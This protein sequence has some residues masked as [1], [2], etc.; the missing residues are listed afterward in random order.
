M[1][2]LTKYSII[3][4]VFNSENIL[5][6]TIEQTVEFLESNQFNYEI[7]LVN[8][9][10]S[11]NSWQVCKSLVLKYP[12]VKAFDLLKNYGQH[13]A[14]LCGINNASGDYIITMDD[15]LQNPPEELIH[16]I[17][18]IN[19]GYDAVFA[20]FKVKQH[21]FTRR[22][23]SKIVNRLN[24]KIFQ[25]PP[26]IV[27][28]NFRIISKKV[29]DR[30]R[31]YKTF[32]PYIPGLILMFSS[33]IAN[34][35]TEHAPRH[36]GVSNYGLGKILKLMARL[37]FNYSS[38][39]L[40]VLTMIG[41]S[42]SMLSFAAGTYYVIKFLFIGVKVPGWTTMVV[43]LSFLNGFMIIMMGVMGEYLGRIM[44]QLSVAQAYQIKEK[45]D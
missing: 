1:P 24:E 30:I 6:K 9:K 39:P 17:N 32:Y 19:E 42:I 5:D 4:P 26:D 3:I 20:K 10:S 37:L 40:K 15:D 43:L 27:L 45:I 31:A 8:D 38:Y 35:E 7:L 41:F 12:H 18:K 13:S 29:A 34:V 14:V 16:L 2:S 44:N 25:K 36:T 21:S 28:T 33:T 22:I 11:D 23:G